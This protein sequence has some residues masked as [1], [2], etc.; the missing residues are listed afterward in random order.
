MTAAPLGAPVPPVVEA[1]RREAF[2]GEVVQEGVVAAHMVAEAVNDQHVGARGARG[3]SGFAVQAR[4][5]R[6]LEGLGLDGGHD[7]SS[8]RA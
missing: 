8:V 2:G 1:V 6:A 3:K 5:V 7:R 4:A